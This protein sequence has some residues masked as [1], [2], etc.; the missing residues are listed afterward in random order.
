MLGEAG[1]TLAGEAPNGVHTQELAVVLLGGA[2]VQVWRETTGGE[3]RLEPA[4]N[5]LLL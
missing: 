2:L 3:E 1:G 4:D 5:L